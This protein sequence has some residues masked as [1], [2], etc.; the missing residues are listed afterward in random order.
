MFS[1]LNILI[2]CHY[3]PGN[4]ALHGNSMFCL[5]LSPTRQREQTLCL[6]SLN[7]QGPTLAQK[8]CSKHLLSE[9]MNKKLTDFRDSS[10]G[11]E[12][13]WEVTSPTRSTTHTA[14]EDRTAI[15]I[16]LE[17]L[18]FQ[19]LSLLDLVLTQ[20]EWIS[21]SPLGWNL[22][23][24]MIIPKMLHGFVSTDISWNW[25]HPTTIKRKMMSPKSEGREADFQ[26]FWKP[27][28]ERPFRKI[29]HPCHSG[30]SLAML[31]SMAGRPHSLPTFLT[32]SPWLLRG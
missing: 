5:W 15:N 3:I 7:I 32:W 6:L 20:Q 28:T 14:P 2:S 17:I 11:T 23:P 10:E 9:W 13:L 29:T 26:E 1:S 21:H 30:D 19:H 8:R 18:L 24:V 31:C 22:C 27:G 4:T 12:G 16:S 25:L